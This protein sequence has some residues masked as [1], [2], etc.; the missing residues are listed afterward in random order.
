M[1]D[2]ILRLLR[3]A[4]V[5]GPLDWRNVV[6]VYG[7]APIPP[8][9]HFAASPGW[10]RGLNLVILSKGTP[11]YFAKCRP[12]GD[13]VLE[14][15]TMIRSC[16]AGERPSGVSVAPV[17]LASSDRLAVQVSPFLRGPHYGRMVR[18]QRTPQYLDTLRMVLR[19]ASE[20]SDLALRDCPPMR[21]PSHQ[22]NLAAA[23]QDNLSAAAQLA[24]LTPDQHRS[25]SDVVCGAN[26]VP[27]RPQHGDFWWQNL[28]IVDGQ[29]WAIDFDSYGE[30]QVPLF[31]DITLVLTTLGV[32]AQGAV[33]G[34][35]RL[36]SDEPEAHA[37]R[38][39]LASRAV[40]E[41]LQP[42]QLDALVVYYLV[43]MAA[44][45]HRRGGLGFSAPHIA[46]VK[47]AAEHLAS[48]RGALL[49]ID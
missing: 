17:T 44:T 45:V 10:N 49:A 7:Y 4:G 25:L 13:V 39:L 33:Q 29:F 32:R 36:S 8:P 42:S 26:D 2:E 43:T 3:E 38:Q 30:L 15:E 6:V 1:N 46:A 22:I 18:R 19:G 41:G 34:L 11:T 12:A 35:A 48:K 47:H 14:R 23:A 31:D 24:E 27:S 20:M 37:C 28:V 5:P 40:A 21:R 16:L 9:K